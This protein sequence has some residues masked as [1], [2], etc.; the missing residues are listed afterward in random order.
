MTAMLLEGITPPAEEERLNVADV[1][2][3]LSRLDGKTEARQLED[4][5]LAFS[6]WIDKYNKLL[7][8]LSEMVVG[9]ANS[10]GG[11]IVLGVRRKASTRATAIEGVGEYDLIQMRRDLYRRVD[12]PF[13][14][15]F[16]EDPEPEGNLLIINVPVGMPPHV[17]SSGV[18]RKRVGTE[19]QPLTR[20]DIDRQVYENPGAIP[21]RSDGIVEGASFDD[22]D[23]VEIEALQEI[24]L[25][26]I[27]DYRKR[28]AELPEYLADLEGLHGKEL[29]QAMRLLRGDDVTLAGLLL[30]GRRPSLRRLIHQH[31]VLFLQVKRVGE[32][33]AFRK[34]LTSCILKVLRQLQELI[35]Q[36]VQHIQITGF[37]EREI[38]LLSWNVVNEAVLNAIAH[39][40]YSRGQ[41]I[42]IE[43]TPDQLSIASPGPFPPGILP[44]NILRHPPVHRN[45][46]LARALQVIGFINRVGFGAEQICEGALRLGKDIPRY[47]CDE[48]H[49]ELIIPMATDRRFLLWLEEEQSKGATFDLRDLLIVRTL[50]RRYQLNRWSTAAAAHMTELDAAEKL[51]SLRSRGYLRARGRGRGTNY[52]LTPV[53]SE[54]LRPAD[55]AAELQLKPKKQDREHAE[56]Q[57]LGALNQTGTVTNAEIRAI[58][59]FTSNRVYRIVKRMEAKGLVRTEGRGRAAVI[60]RGDGIPDNPS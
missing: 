2:R 5:H 37:G 14:V 56:E 32:K 36:G 10:Q 41:G 12:P 51:S 15:D 38:P 13:L 49:V 48:A 9:F 18:G 31:E 59:G 24:L 27:D 33:D 52:E 43:F 22:L 42:Q 60:H 44:E 50:M 35:P 20:R 17:T 26:R 3:R 6:P 45:E 7:D 53:L 58:T 34:E 29:L 25:N 55:A 4:E 19:F 39:R 23:P 57:I 16:V 47:N 1:R 30:V 46:T 40:D 11:T 21:D 54:R 28:Q 8:V